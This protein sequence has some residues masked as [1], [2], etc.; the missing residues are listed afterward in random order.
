MAWR[1]ITETDLVTRISGP[2]L[3][4]FREAALAD[5]QAD[6]VADV[7]AQIATDIRG[8]VAACKQNTV[9][10]EGTI[11]ESL[12]GTALD[13]I[14]IEIQTRAAGILI[15]P[16]DVRKRK[17]ERAERRLRDVAAC[18]FAIEQ[19]EE[20]TEETFGGQGPA[21]SAPT[22]LFDHDDQDGI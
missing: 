16:E 3:E 13:L 15:D 9:G 18:K 22:R 19:P 12:L 4:G 8:Y 5:D 2:E 17:M 10:P 20:Q 1:A 7:L 11:P 14:V 21:S 6:P